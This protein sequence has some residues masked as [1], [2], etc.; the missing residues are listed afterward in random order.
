MPWYG[1]SYYGGWR[2]ES[3]RTGALHYLP[4][5]GAGSGRNRACGTGRKEL[6]SYPAPHSGAE[7]KLAR[8]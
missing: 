5:V 4:P 3:L 7:E 2:L 6:A 8:Y 1:Y